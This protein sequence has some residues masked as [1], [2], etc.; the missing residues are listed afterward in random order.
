MYATLYRL[1]AKNRMR[2]RKNWIAKEQIG[3]NLMWLCGFD[4]VVIAIVIVIAVRIIVSIPSYV[5]FYS[6]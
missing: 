3:F 5:P 4:F 2:R 1:A 6:V